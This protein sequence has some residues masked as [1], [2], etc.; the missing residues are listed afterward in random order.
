MFIYPNSFKS[1]S[2]EWISEDEWLLQMCFFSFT[3]SSMYNHVVFGTILPKH[4]QNLYRELSLVF[5]MRQLCTDQIFFCPLHHPKI[6]HR[7]NNDG[8]QI[9]VRKCLCWED[10]WW[11]KQSIFTLYFP[12]RWYTHMI[13]HG[14]K[15]RGKY[16][17]QM[18]YQRYLKGWY[19]AVVWNVSVFWGVDL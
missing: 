19:F 11:L 10:P 16:I 18:V 3:F 13:L 2:H 14:D 6:H 5:L 12:W 17:Y 9:S 4:P 8:T 7:A 1:L 15:Y